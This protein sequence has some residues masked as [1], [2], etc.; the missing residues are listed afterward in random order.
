MNDE[1]L[2][3]MLY[4]NSVNSFICVFEYVMCFADVSSA[5][6][7]DYDMICVCVCLTDEL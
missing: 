6:F 2:L 5:I 7:Y 3:T 4:V 1:L